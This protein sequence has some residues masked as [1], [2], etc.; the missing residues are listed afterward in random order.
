MGGDTLSYD[1]DTA[2]PATDILETKLLLNSTIS[3]ADAAARFLLCDLKDYCG[4]KA[5]FFCLS[6]Y[7]RLVI[8]KCIICRSETFWSK[9]K[10]LKSVIT[11]LS[12]WKY[13]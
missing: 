10:F 6:A 13:G 5:A 9:W 3:D 7:A 11:A 12:V 4:P 2:S 8:L 1:D